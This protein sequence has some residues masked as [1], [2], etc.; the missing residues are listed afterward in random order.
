MGFGVIAVIVQPFIKKEIVIQN[1]A[2]IE[3]NTRPAYNTAITYTSCDSGKAVTQSVS[4]YA[5]VNVITGTIIAI[6]TDALI[7]ADGEGVA[8]TGNDGL[9]FVKG[10]GYI[11]ANIAAR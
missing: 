8:E 11:D 6:E 9:Y 7:M 5:A 4:S 3:V 2:V 1:K 10:D